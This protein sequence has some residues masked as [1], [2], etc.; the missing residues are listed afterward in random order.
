MPERLYHLIGSLPFMLMTLD[1]KP[2][3]NKTRIIE[4]IIYAVVGG[5]FS[6]YV[7]V[8]VI[9]VKIDVLEKKV[10]KIYMDIYR[11]VMPRP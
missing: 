5:L 3:I 6:G 10:D 11:P 7:A 2:H 8:K 4:S 9:E 1:G